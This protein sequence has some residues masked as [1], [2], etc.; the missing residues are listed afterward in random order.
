MPIRSA[1]RDQV[2]SFGRLPHIP[3]SLFPALLVRGASP[4]LRAREEVKRKLALTRSGKE[5]ILVKC[6]SLRNEQFSSRNTG[7][8]MA[9]VTLASVSLCV[10]FASPLA[11]ATGNTDV[12]VQGVSNGAQQVWNIFV[13]IVAPIAALMLCICCF[14]IVAGS[15]RDAE[16][17]RAN[18][19]RIIIGIAG[20]LLAP[21]IVGAIKSWFTQSGW[22]F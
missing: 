14:K 18:V 22:A 8:F 13:G 11:F 3:R 12:I 9:A 19:A 16:A 17:A 4:L 2:H 7:A 15:Q 20:V 10:M 6:E 21:S 5:M 1:R